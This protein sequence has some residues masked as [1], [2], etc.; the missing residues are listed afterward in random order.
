MPSAFTQTVRSR[1]FALVIHLGLWLLLYLT[2]VNLRG[3]APPYRNVNSGLSPQVPV[4]AGKLSGLFLGD[5]LPPPGTNTSANPFF[6]EHFVPP[7]TPA[8]PPPPTSRKVEVT[9]QGFFESTENVRHAVMVVG[10]DLVIAKTGALVET[11]V[12]VSQAGLQVLTLTNLAAQTNLLPLNVKTV[13]EV[14]I[15]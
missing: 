13:I 7:P 6:T 2:L 3:T 9:Y 11:N 10:K 12:F 15:K 14:P 4:P 5:P 8:P 1:W